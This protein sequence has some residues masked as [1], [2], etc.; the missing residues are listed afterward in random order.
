MSILPSKK[1]NYW[2]SLS[3]IMT[4][5][6]VIFLFI[7]ITYMRQIQKDHE[8]Q[9]RVLEEYQETYIALYDTL[10]TEFEDDFAEN[11]WHAELSEDLSIRF[12]NEEVLFDFNSTEL[13]PEFQTILEDFF[14]RY[15]DIL[16]NAQFREK[17]AEVRI[18]GHT[19]SRGE[20]MFNVRLSQNRTSN[21]LDFLFNRDGSEYNSL[22]GSDQELLRYWFT[23]TGFSFGRT[24][25]SEGLLSHNTG[26]PENRVRSRRVE[27]RIVM[28]SEEV[29]NQML[30]LMN[31]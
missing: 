22:A 27:F 26:N 7:A 18:E 1:E 3:D 25:D 23:T 14:P 11:K 9:N 8:N 13:K 30:E 6:M 24:M 4:V 21:V 20:Y 12:L 5:L 28:K 31:E 16:L 15:L 17:I 19:D 10:K 2:V 29:L